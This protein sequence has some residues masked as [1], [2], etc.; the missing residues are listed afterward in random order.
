MPCH[1]VD[2][3]G[4]GTA[5]V[6]TANPPPVG[7]CSSCGATARYLCDFPVLKEKGAQHTLT[8][9]RPVCHLCR[10]RIGTE[11]DLCRAHAPLWDFEK[12]VPKVGPGAAPAGEEGR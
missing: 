9:D 1:R 3:P 12:N 5:L 8:C 4:G 2:L 7:P 10:T 11:R 6:R